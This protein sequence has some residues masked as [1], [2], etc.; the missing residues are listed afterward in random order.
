MPWGD[1]NYASND[2]VS[3]LRLRH[4]CD[5]DVLVDYEMANEDDMLAR[6]L[7]ESAQLGCDTYDEDAMLAQVLAESAR[8][9]GNGI[10]QGPIEA[11]E[12]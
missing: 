12:S 6:V 8:E 1:P 11:I 5:Y 7:A 2:F 10:D 3:H 9:C 4:K